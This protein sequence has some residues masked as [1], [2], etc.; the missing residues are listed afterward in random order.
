MVLR[1]E[2]SKIPYHLLFI[3]LLLVLTTIY[4]ILTSGNEEI[5]LKTGLL[6]TD[7]LLNNI[8]TT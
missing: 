8:D 7:Y 1:L 6:I 2:R 3:I 4:A 5:P